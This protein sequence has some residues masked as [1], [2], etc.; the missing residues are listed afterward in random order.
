M[1]TKA[2]TANWVPNL[3]IFSMNLVTNIPKWEIYKQESKR[4]TISISPKQNRER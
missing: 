4:I 3:T 2:I 1:C